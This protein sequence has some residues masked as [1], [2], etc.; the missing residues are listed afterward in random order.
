MEHFVVA[1]DLS[2][3]DHIVLQNLIRDVKRH[4]RQD[5]SLAE[6]DEGYISQESA[7]N[8]PKVPQDDD[9]PELDDEVDI[10]KLKALNDPT[11]P[12]Y[13]PSITSMW[14]LRDMAANWPPAIHRHIILP[15]ASWAKGFVRHETDVIMLTHLLLYLTTS[16]TSAIMLYRNFHLLHGI[17]HFAMQFYYMGPYTLM[18]HQHIHMGGVLA[19]T[20]LLG[21]VDKAFPYILDP[22]MGHTWNSY[23]YHHVKH[24]HVEGNGPSDLSSTI[25]Y[26]RD[27]VFH[28]LHYLGRFFFFVWFDLPLYFLKKGQIK[29]AIK[30]GGWEL[31]N[32]TMLYTLYRLNSQAT[33][34]VLLCPFLLMRLGLMIGNWAQHA[35]VDADEPDSDFR[36]SITLIDVP[37]RAAPLTKEKMIY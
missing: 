22:L 37:V 16:V 4:K 15:Y 14:D 26:Q 6:G 5:G 17:L 18:M 9:A 12:D 32:Y 13:E 8:S 27:D 11:S 28:F 2:I 1:S 29:Y 7:G 23:Y 20:P 3:S 25:R 31:L 21:L 34:F 33:T 30:A 10:N 35:F 36:S 24:H 19:K